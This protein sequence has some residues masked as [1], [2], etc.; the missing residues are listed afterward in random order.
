MPKLNTNKKKLNI[1]QFFLASLLLALLAVNTLPGLRASALDVFA[2]GAV[3]NAAPIAEE[4]ILMVGG[5][6]SQE[7]GEGRK[8]TLRHGKETL[9]AT[10]RKGETVVQLLSRMGASITAPELV[11]VDLLGEGIDIEIACDFVLYE[12]VTEAAAHTSIYTESYD[13]LKG[14]YE[15]VQEGQD[16]ERTVVY[17]LV[18]A[19]GQFVSR[20]AVEEI[21][22]TSVPEIAYKGV[23]VLR[24]QEGDTIESVIKND[25]GSGYLKMKSGDV[26]RFTGSKQV[27]CTA[28]TTGHDGVGTVTYTGTTVKRGCAAVDKKVIPLGTEMFIT[29]L[30]GSY[31]YGMARAEDT[32]VRGDTIDLYMDSYE[33]CISFGARKSIAYFLATE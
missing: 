2:D 21:S 24:A 10:S 31:T 27:K 28:Y 23:R 17:E 32:G 9:Y 14:E 6:V 5:E 33:E 1:H 22:N 25:D 11:K 30:S 15:V 19:D 16:G 26:L 12:T 13:L 18:Y 29:T 7:L 8:V 20:Q 3:E 4:R